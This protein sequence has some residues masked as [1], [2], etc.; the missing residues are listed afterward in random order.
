MVG[1]GFTE[2][3]RFWAKVSL[4]DAE[5]C[6]LWT[7]AIDPQTGYGRFR[8]RT[9][10]QNAHKLSLLIAEGPPSVPGLEAAHGCRYRHCVAPAHLS[11]KTRQENVD[12]Q[13]RDGTRAQG[14]MIV[15]HKLIA[16]EVLVI[17]A[18]YARGD[19]SQTALAV[20]YGVSRRAISHIITRSTWRHL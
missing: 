12:D 16:S 14:E 6:M 11:W 7:G 19:V 2:K 5:G 10:T 1:R 15:Q 3:Q 9:N 4:P 13:L 17:R 8:V 18:R 20:E